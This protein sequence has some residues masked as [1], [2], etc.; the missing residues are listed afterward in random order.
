MSYHSMT[1]LYVCIYTTICN[2]VLIRTLYIFVEAFLRE[3]GFASWNIRGYSRW[4]CETE[5]RVIR[6]PVERAVLELL[7]RDG[8]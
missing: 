8:A 2:Y 1:R 4:K 5:Y 6:I 3:R 7:I